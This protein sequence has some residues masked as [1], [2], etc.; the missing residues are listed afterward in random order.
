MI[1][2]KKR[3]YDYFTLE[4]SEYGDSSLSLEPKG[5]IKV[6]ISEIS[7]STVNNIL[8][9]DCSYI[10]LT[11]AEID[12][13]FVIQYGDLKLKV[14]HVNAQGRYKQVFMGLYE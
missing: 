3:N 10:G 8:Y 12:D 13:T 7:N 6:F 5:K 2:A 11:Y 1:N 14:K 9:K 4:V